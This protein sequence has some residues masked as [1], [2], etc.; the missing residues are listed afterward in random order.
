[1]VQKTASQNGKCNGTGQVR[2]T[3]QLGNMIQQI[4][5]SCPDCNEQEKE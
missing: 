5:R 2:I 3:R 1:M 4:V